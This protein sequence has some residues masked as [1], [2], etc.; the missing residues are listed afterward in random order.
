[1][2]R[3]DTL[4]PGVSRQ[5]ACTVR[6]LISALAVAASL[7]P[8]ARAAGPMPAAELLDVEKAFAVTARIVDDKT[9][10]LRYV[11]AKGYYMYRDRFRF[12][13]NGEPVSISR[14]A[15]PAGKW[16]QDATFGKVVTFRNG[17]RLLLPVSLTLLDDVQTGRKS[18]TLISNSQGCA[19]AG[20][21]YPPL[22]QTLVLIPGSTVWVS[23][24]N[25]IT[26]GFSHGPRPHSGLADRLTTG[27]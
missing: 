19:D 16:K 10:E 11:I 13:I 20:I 4:A 14:Q 22:R 15:W 21:C 6:L 1:M 12:S 7:V 5:F 17:V 23:P 24:Q 25:E 8:L 3:T 26:L 9:L 18:F 27:N 2:N